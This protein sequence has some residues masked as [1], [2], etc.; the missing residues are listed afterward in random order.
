MY[1][2]KGNE[3]FVISGKMPKW[4]KD[5]QKTIRE[6]RI[7]V[8]RLGPK[9]RF[10]LIMTYQLLAKDLPKPKPEPERQVAAVDPGQRT[11]GTVYTPRGC[12]CDACGSGDAEKGTGKLIALL[13]RESAA[14]A[15]RA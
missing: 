7:V 3:T 13:K 8:E 14:K 4:T 9:P 11:L 10:R 2:G 12:L 5:Y 6:C 15:K 1:F